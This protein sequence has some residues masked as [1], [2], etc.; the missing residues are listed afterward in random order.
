L[1]SEEGFLDEAIKMQQE[2]LELQRGHGDADLK[3]ATLSILP[4]LYEA[5]NQFIQVEETLKQGLDLRRE[6]PGAGVRDT[7]VAMS[8]EGI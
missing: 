2:T 3:L 8:S 6:K 5:R 7:L 1:C 4:F